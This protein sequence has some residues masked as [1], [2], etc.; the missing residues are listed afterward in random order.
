MNIRKYKNDD[1]LEIYNLFYD[2]VHSVNLK[3][4]NEEQINVWAKKNIDLNQWCEKFQYSYTLIAEENGLIVG[5][6][7]IENDGYLNMLYVHKDYQH[8]GIASR[9]L[10]ELEEYSTKQNINQII[11]YSSKTAE[12]FFSNKGYEITENNIVV[13]NKVELEN[14]LMKKELIKIG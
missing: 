3:D 6:A 4:Y 5:F 13:R 14:Y 10:N 11:T 9:L 7:N 8:K 1:N 12:P 2:T